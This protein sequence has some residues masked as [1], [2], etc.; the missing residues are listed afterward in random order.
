MA[1]EQTIPQQPEN[2][3]EVDAGNTC[4]GS[5]AYIYRPGNVCPKC[6][7]GVLDYDGLLNVFCPVCGVVDSG[8]F[9]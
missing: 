1:C 7:K 2:R 5:K 4:A 9:T 6:G 8:S 3:T